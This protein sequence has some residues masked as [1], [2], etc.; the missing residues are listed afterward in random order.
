MKLLLYPILVIVLLQS[1]YAADL[2][3]ELCLDSF[4]GLFNKPALLAS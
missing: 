3:L 2:L 1:G 4:N